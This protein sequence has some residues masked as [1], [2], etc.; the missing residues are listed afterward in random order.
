M[1]VI[2]SY[3]RTSGIQMELLLQVLRVVYDT[4]SSIDARLS[5][6][7]HDEVWPWL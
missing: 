6:V 2:F 4:A 3:G 7:F 5:G 1:V